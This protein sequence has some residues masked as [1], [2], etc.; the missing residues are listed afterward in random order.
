MRATWTRTK[1]NSP[2][3]V[4]PTPTSSA[5]Q[6]DSRKSQTTTV[7][8]TSLPTTII[9]TMVASNGTLAR[10]LAG[11]I[12]API[13]TKNSATKTSRSGKSRASVS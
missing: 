9:A 11:S 2:I 4:S 12:S 13:V 7:L 10:R 8:S 6:K 5:V 1:E 3:C